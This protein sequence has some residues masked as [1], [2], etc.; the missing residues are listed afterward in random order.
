MVD[1][2]SHILWAVDDGARSLAES[3]AIGRSA[4]DAG[5][6]VMVATPHV[7]ADD[8]SVDI[9]SLARRVQNLNEALR[10]EGIPLVVETGAE[11]DASCLLTLARD[12]L[13][14]VALARSRYVLVETPYER[15]PIAAS[16]EPLVRHAIGLGIR[17]V[18]AHPERNPGLATIQLVEGLVAAGALVQVTAASLSGEFGARARLYALE[19]IR[20]GLAHVIASDVHRPGLRLAALAELGRANASEFGPELVQRLSSLLEEIPAAIVAD[21]DVRGPLPA[22]RDRS[23]S[24]WGRRLQNVLTQ[25]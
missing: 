8:R 1:L 4:S 14:L 6:N 20:A 17:P 22:L 5:V 3:L 10:V 9:R 24:R 11:V 21:R 16:F 12:E 7:R 25:R 19:L 23:R 2:H 13:E 18:L 15:D